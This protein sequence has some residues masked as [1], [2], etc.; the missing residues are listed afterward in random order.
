MLLNNSI[1]AGV[2]L[3]PFVGDI[4]LAQ[5]KANSRNAALLE[6]FLRIRGEVYLQM[7]AENKDIV[8]ASAGKTN[9][10]GKWKGKGKKEVAANNSEKVKVD[11]GEGKEATIPKDTTRS[12]GE[13][14]K[15]GAGL[16]EGEVVPDESTK[17]TA[18]NESTA[19]RV[20]NGKTHGKRRLSFTLWRGKGTEKS[21]QANNRGRFV[22]DLAGTGEPVSGDTGTSAHT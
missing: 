18:A 20:S 13:Q 7:K 1:S 15:P 21:K 3:I 16:E 8:Q 22:E 10:I 2:G 19:N 5:F 4:F 6:E 14:I 11:V 17:T 9:F 12:D